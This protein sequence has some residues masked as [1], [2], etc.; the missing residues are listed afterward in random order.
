MVGTPSRRDLLRGLLA[1]PATRFLP[2]AP[3]PL[4]H[5]VVLGGSRQFTLAA[6]SVLGERFFWF[7]ISEGRGRA[8][9]WGTWK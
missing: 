2:A 5:T 3:A 9:S 1:L 4:I 8:L 7:V 6:P